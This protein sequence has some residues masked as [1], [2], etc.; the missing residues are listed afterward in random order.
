MTTSNSS[1][2]ETL[3]P[4]V[5]LGA[6]SP[7][8]LDYQLPQKATF[9]LYGRIPKRVD[10]DWFKA[11]CK[12]VPG[13]DWWSQVGSLTSA[14]IER[15]IVG[16]LQGQPTAANLIPSAAVVA[17]PLPKKQSSA[18]TSTARRAGATRAAAVAAAATSDVAVERLQAETVKAAVASGLRPITFEHFGG[19]VEVCYLPRPKTPTPRIT[20]IEEYRVASYLGRY[21]AGKTVGTFSLLPGEKTTI[22]VR[23]YEDRSETSTEAQNILDSFSE[24]SAEE[25]EATLQE[26]T[27]E[28]QENSTS[29]GVSTSASVGVDINLLG[30]V[31]ADAGGDVSTDVETSSTR[32]SF[33]NS[34]ANSVEKHVA[35]TSSR[36]EVQVNTTSSQSVAS[37]E[38]QS[39]VRTLENINRSRVLNFVMR[40]LQQE[41]LTITYLADLKFVYSNGYPETV[42]IVDLPELLDL[43]QRKL[44]PNHVR[45]AFALLLKP[46]CSVY[47]HLDQRFR[48]V[49]EVTESFEDCPF[50]KDGET[51]TYWR[52]PKKL[53]DAYQGIEVPGVILNVTTSV[54]QTASVIAE[55]LLGQ[56]E[57]LDTH[58]R[59]LQAAAVE[60]ARLDNQRVALGIET[61][62]AVTDPVQ[63]AAAFAQVF[64][65][66]P[67]DDEDTAE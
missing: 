3:P 13:N 14:D 41:Y 25:F 36:R 64:A 17:R 65:P 60:A 12:K 26:E 56:G 46:Y 61:V 59:E 33:A 38:E 55:A 29:V 39:T 43:L 21:G 48:F 5:T 24:E 47:N 49:E 66:A 1:D 51:F 15:E 27:G 58:N 45:K 50:A 42:E 62:R 28:S 40:Q 37:G 32:Q 11:E 34:I 63:R 18:L 30:I 8:T 9:S 20:V 6:G 22:T 44:E 54:L 10:P 19:R 2:S 53:L 16:V 31:G 7:A 52:R 57:A 35:S 23:T 67:A 4:L